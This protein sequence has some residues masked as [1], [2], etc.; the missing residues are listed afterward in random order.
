M[1]KPLIILLVCVAGLYGCWKVLV[2]TETWRYRLTLTVNDN[3]VLRTGS[4]V[5]EIGG[6]ST[7]D[8]PL[9]IPGNTGGIG[10][11]RGEAVVIDLGKKG[12]LFAL[13]K[14]ENDSNHAAY[15][16][17]NIFGMPNEVGGCAGAATPEGIRYYAKLKG[18]SD[19]PIK[20]L[21]M[22]VR[23]RDIN[24]PKTIEKVD[25][26]NLEASFGSG[27]TLENATIEMTGDAITIGIERW[28]PWLPKYYNMRFDGERYGNFESTLPL[29]NS[30][31][32]GNFS[33][34]LSDGR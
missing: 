33:T 16:V 26:K 29:A 25:P 32:S 13:L 34:E 17:C 2:P 3:G 14:S 4:S 1:K 8:L 7:R 12:M 9:P 21:P 28:L 19:V 30:L 18:K 22:L 27:V 5:I 23:F 6:R 20:E 10:V 15:I 31:A 11:A 24:D